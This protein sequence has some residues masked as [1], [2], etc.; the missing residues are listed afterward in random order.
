MISEKLKIKFGTKELIILV[1]L[2]SAIFFF[3][4]YRWTGIR[5][6]VGIILLYILPFYIFLDSFDLT[7]EEKL[8][9]SFFIGLGMVSLTVYYL[10]KILISL[11]VSIIVCFLLL[12][13]SSLVF[14][15]FY[16][17]RKDKKLLLEKDID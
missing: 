12:L 4:A 1:L 7:L 13:I 6:F 17:K 14:R 11:R 3:W 16:K 9:F 15:Y 8:I 2:I 5:L 10:T